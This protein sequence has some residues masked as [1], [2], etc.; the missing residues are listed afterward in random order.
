M[1]FRLITNIT[2]TVAL[3]AIVSLASCKKDVTSNSGD[4]AATN[5]SD[6][7]TSADNAYYDVLNNAFVGFADNSSIWNSNSIHSGKTTTMSTATMGTSQIGCA[8]YSFDDAVPGEYPKTMT[9]DFG[10]GCTGADGIVRSGKIAYL[11][12]G[13]V[14]SP[15]TTVGVTFTNF[16]SNGYGV[17]G[18]Y[19][20]TNNSSDQVG[21]SFNTQV[22]N[23][24]ITYPN[25]TNYHYSHNK[26]FIQ[27]AG[28]STVF[29][30]TDDVYSIS[31]TSSFSNAEGNSLV[32]TADPLAPLQKAVMCAHISK[33][34]VKFVYNQAISGSIDFGDGTCDNSAVLY[35]GS[36]H[37]LITLR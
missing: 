9:M 27:T 8:I 32:F 25:Q 34:V 5:L 26:T 33:G 15:G 4:T 19:T 37:S 3:L 17:Q 31:G 14:V 2:K 11:F 21:I 35:V 6:S 16:V 13:P 20:I 7:S 23:G 28:T 36:Q 30:I 18:Q 10:T 22:I 1:N 24:I 12:S 29:D